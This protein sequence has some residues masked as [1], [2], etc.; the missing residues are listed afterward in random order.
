M[1]TIERITSRLYGLNNREIIKI[2][3]SGQ[4]TGAYKKDLLMVSVYFTANTAGLR[5]Y[6]QQ[7]ELEWRVFFNGARAFLDY[8]GAFASASRVLRF[9]PDGAA[10]ASTLRS[11]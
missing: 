8:C 6:C 2:N 7:M 10:Q 4:T 5:F 3:I 11:C 9:L 1:C